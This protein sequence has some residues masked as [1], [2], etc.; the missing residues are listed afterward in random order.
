MRSVVIRMPLET[1]LD[2]SD[3]PGASV[4]H[5][6]SEVQHEVPK[7]LGLCLLVREDRTKPSYG[8]TSVL[9]HSAFKDGKFH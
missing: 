9:S 8:A 2:Q 6:T 1:A 4:R 5:H 7:G 3:Q